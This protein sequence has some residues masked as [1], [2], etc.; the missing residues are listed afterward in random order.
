MSKYLLFFLILAAFNPLYGQENLRLQDAVEFGLEN[1]YGIKIARENENISAN[2]YTIGNAGFLPLVGVNAS[3]NYSVENTRQEFI[4]NRLQE[5]DG[6]KSE[7]FAAD[8]GLQWTIFD[9]MGMFITY[10]KLAELKEA[11]NLNVKV[12]I[13]NTIADISAAFYQVVLAK[14]RLNV[15]QNTLDLSRERRTISKTKYEVGKASKLEFLA[16][17]VDYNADTSAL[18]TQRETL[19][20]AK[21]DLNRLMGRNPAETFEVTSIIELGRDLELDSLIETAMLNNPSYQLLR[22]EKNIAMLEI[23]EIQAE[24]L[25]QLNLNAG[26]LYNTSS[27]EAGFLVSRRSYG[28]TYGISANMPIFDGFNLNRRVQNARIQSEIAEMGIQDFQLELE[29]EIRK[30]HMNYLNNL[31]LIGL[32]K[33]NLE[34][35]RE[36]TEIA[37]ERYRLGNSDAL[38]LREAQLNSAAAESR[39]LNATFITK[40]SEIELL[41]LSGRIM[42]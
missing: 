13:E 20:N 8:V 34:V 15:L 23:K 22:K 3:K 38:E 1:N 28:P 6:A 25:P 41:R 30:T 40:L 26:Y 9:G 10:D 24:R 37:L 7:R 29:T 36:N 17:Q 32:E 21:T 2:N 33:Q 12:V 19:Y 14:E 42:D 31:T 39:L 11:G 4:E 16:A 27:A 35:A 18:I 5:R